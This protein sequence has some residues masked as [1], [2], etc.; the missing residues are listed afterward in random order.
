M[1]SVIH[2]NKALTVVKDKDTAA[3]KTNTKSSRETNI[4]N[5]ANKNHR[6]KSETSKNHK[7]LGLPNTSLL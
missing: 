5:Y 6:I 2:I 7:T 1:E 4:K 3:R